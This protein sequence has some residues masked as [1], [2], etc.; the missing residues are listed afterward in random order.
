MEA[1]DPRQCLPRRE[2]EEEAVLVEEEAGA[3][4]P[5]VFDDA[6]R[7]RVTKVLS[8]Y[9]GRAQW[10]MIP[11]ATPSSACRPSFYRQY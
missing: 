4:Q 7:Q 1:F 9:C 10:I 3:G 2:A 8:N 6:L 5:F 11:P